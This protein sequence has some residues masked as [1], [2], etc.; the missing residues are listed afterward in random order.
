M[1]ALFKCCE[2]PDQLPHLSW[3]HA[4]SGNTSQAGPSAGLV[5]RGRQRRDCGAACTSCR[6]DSW[7]SLVTPDALRV[8]LRAAQP[9]FMDRSSHLCGADRIAADVAIG[10]RQCYFPL[11]QRRLPA[12]SRGIV[13]HQ[14]LAADG[15]FRRGPLGCWARSCRPDA[16]ECRLSRT[17]RDTDFQRSP[18]GRH[19]HPVRARSRHP[20]RSAAGSARHAAR[21]Q[22]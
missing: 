14:H 1:R 7:R 19:G 3:A 8:W 10:Q 17:R 22:A 6:A 15:C 2:G 13:Q 21:N 20:A 4:L 11:A 9:P 5:T 16:A 12:V 18:T